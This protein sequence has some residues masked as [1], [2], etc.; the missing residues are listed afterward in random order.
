MTGLLATVGVAVVLLASAYAGLN[1]TDSNASVGIEITPV[2]ETTP[3]T[4]PTT[5]PTAPPEPTATP[6]PEADVTNRE[7][8]N[9]IRGTQ[10]LSAEERTW[11]LAN[12][13]NR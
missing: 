10:Y 6:E 4:I 7:D 5:V 8:C 12:C 11:Y 9:T 1:A 13:V 2:S 3:V